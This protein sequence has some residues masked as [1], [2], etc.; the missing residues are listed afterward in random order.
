MRRGLLAWY[1][2]NARDLPWRRTRDPYRVWL[3]E[4]LLQQT[5]V[6]TVL[7]YYERFVAAFPTVEALA[8]A[9]PDRVLK[10]WQ[11]LGYYSR[12]RNLL[13][14]ARAIVDEHDG[15][16]PKTAEQWRALP[17][18]GRY[19]AGAIASIAFGERTPVLD[20]NV[21]RVL[22]RVFGVRAS[23][24]EV[25]TQNALWEMADALVPARTAGDFN[26]ALMELGARVCV[27][28]RPRCL[29]CPVRARCDAHARG[30]Q[31]S[32]PARRR[33]KPVPHVEI[34][35]GAIRR[36]GRYLM[37]QRPA[38]S[39]LGGLWEF[40]GG[41]IENGETHAQALARELQEEL[42]VDADIGEHLVSVDHTYSHFSITLHVY[43][44]RVRRGRPKPVY[45]SALQWIARSEFDRYAFPAATVKVLDRLA[46]K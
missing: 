10:L 15:R 36:G 16:F 38:Q 32:L 12:A 37:G 24:D 2:A 31:D 28:K 44:C 7:E 8:A 18:V 5:R 45:H 14:A 25:A 35:A 20:G 41:K 17:G 26:Q 46:S 33:K 40:P 13:E 27:P 29:T 6:E 23:I 30:E 4:V 11:G 42:G 22:A 3:S 39:M 21:K 19:T 43:A 34:V 9:S 1:R